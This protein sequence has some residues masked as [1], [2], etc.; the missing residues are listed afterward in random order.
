MFALG[1]Q[2]PEYFLKN[3]FY[4]AGSGKLYHPN[5]PPK[6][7]MPTSWTEYSDALPVGQPG[8]KNL[9][10]NLGMVKKKPGHNTTTGEGGQW[11]RILDCE[12]NDG[13]SLLTEQAISLKRRSDRFLGFRRYR[14]WRR[15]R[16]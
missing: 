5:R 4:V 7:D 13:E 12:E 16:G 14:R 11:T 2:P 6:N 3:G 8:G 15:G 9:T 1:T 10:C